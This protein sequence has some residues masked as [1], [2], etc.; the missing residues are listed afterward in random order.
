[1]SCF[2]VLG[3]KFFR[4]TNTQGHEQQLML[5]NS[6]CD[7]HEGAGGVMGINN[8]AGCW[9]SANKLLLVVRGR[10]EYWQGTEIWLYSLIYWFCWC[11]L[12]CLH[13]GGWNHYREFFT[14]IQGHKEKLLGQQRK[15]WKRHVKVEQP[16][17]LSD[18]MYSSHKPH[19]RMLRAKNT[20]NLKGNR[21]ETF[22]KEATW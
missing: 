20:R 1:M 7:G 10:K 21:K 22:P 9:G 16:N 8:P 14:L 12:S 15:S 2:E 11:C 4:L 5:G 18:H 19:Q 6:S 3:R 17:S 13:G